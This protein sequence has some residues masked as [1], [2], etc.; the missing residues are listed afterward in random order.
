MC[1]VCWH[2][3]LNCVIAAAQMFA[4]TAEGVFL[5]EVSFTFATD[6]EAKVYVIMIYINLC[7]TIYVLL[8]VVTCTVFR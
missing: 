3:T 5:Q 6:N 8:S 7:A 2:T 1:T 4:A